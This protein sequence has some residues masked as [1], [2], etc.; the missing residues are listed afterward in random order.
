MGH[1]QSTERYKLEPFQTQSNPLDTYTEAHEYE[2]D[3]IDEEDHQTVDSNSERSVDTT[4][5]LTTPNTPS[6]LGTT[7]ALPA[8]IPAPAQI[9]N[10]SEQ[11]QSTQLSPAQVQSTQ[12][13][14]AQVQSAQLPPAQVSRG[15][16]TTVFIPYSDEMNTYKRFE[17][18]TSSIY[19]N[20]MTYYSITLDL[21]AL[22][23]KAQR[24]LYVES[25]TYCELCLYGLM[26]PTILISC[27]CTVLSLALKN[28]AGGPIVISSLNAFNAFCL[29]LITYLKLDAKAEAHKAT[30]YQFDK[31]TTLCEFYSGKVQMY[32]QTNISDKV[33]AFVDTIIE[34][35]IT[36]I[37]DVNQ[38]IIPE[39]I[40]LRYN[41]FYYYNVFEIMRRHNTN[42]VLVNQE[43]LMVLNNIKNERKDSPTMQKLVDRRE[44]LIGDVINYR[45]MT[46]EISRKFNNEI[47]RFNEYRQKNACFN[48]FMC[49][50][51]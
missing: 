5:T 46:S 25:K 10:V 26:L 13:S 48:L 34:K 21:I 36:E 14:P 8:S 19:M 28:T 24:I 38:F 49:L 17:F 32:R 47:T 27:L 40:R 31:L 41:L 20:E 7:L 6:I 12:L 16:E 22:Y 50:K 11:V 15:T 37:K 18:E 2:I 1:S 3:D 9:T 4:T 44:K 35:K 23:L 42:I 29:S 33:K 43:L 39:I 30:A 51:T 45:T